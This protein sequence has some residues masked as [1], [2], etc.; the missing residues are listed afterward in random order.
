MS[1]NYSSLAVALADRPQAAAGAAEPLQV[2]TRFGV[3]E[4]DAD[5]L[6][7]MERGLLGFPQSASYALLDLPGEQGQAFRLLQNVDDASIGF[8]VLPLGG[9][10]AK[11]AEAD[12]Q[13]ICEQR[14]MRREDAVFLLIATLRP[15]AEGGLDITVNRRAPVLIDT[16]RMTGRQVV[17]NDSR[18]EV[19]FQ[20]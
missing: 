4:V 5:K 3:Y 8:V 1:M 9:D 2:S 6:L 16:Q 7:R 17:L 20:L 15:K 11:D 12:L 13:A 19:Q 10:L 18:Y 14:H